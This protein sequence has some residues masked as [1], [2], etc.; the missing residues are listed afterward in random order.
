[1]RKILMTLAGG[2]LAAG[3]HAQSLDLHNVNYPGIYCHFDNSCSENPVDQTGTFTPTNAAVTCVLT[4]HSFPGNNMDSAGT[5]GYEYQLTLN[6]NGSTDSNVVSV[7]SLTLNFGQPLPFA[8]GEH[9]SNYVWI[10]TIGGPNGLA[11]S[12]ADMDGQKVV[13]H[14]DPPLSLNT[15][16]DQTTNSYY[17]GLISSNAPTTA[18]AILSGSVDSAAFK[19]SLRAQAP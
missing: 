10:V 13:V 14:F 17:F 19:A 5:Y 2:F 3:V 6:N 4:S 18:T 12:G 7:S 9:A 1:M 8:F 15:S 16:T 11:P